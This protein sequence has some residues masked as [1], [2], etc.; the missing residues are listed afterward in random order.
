VPRKASGTVEEH[1]WADG[2]TITF[3]LRI[4]FE[5]QRQR[6]ELGTNREGWNRE[7]AD[8]ERE[9]IMGQIERG[10]WQPPEPEPDPE[11]AEDKDQETL[12]V[13]ATRYFKKQTAGQIPPKTRKDL[14]WRLSYILS[15]KQVDDLVCQTDARWVDD[16]KTWLKNIVSDH[17]KRPLK[18]RS[19][20]MVLT[21]LTSI[22]EDAVDYNVLP[23]NPGKGSRRRVPEGE[24]RRH[25][26]E[27]DMVVDFLDV[28]GRWDAE[29]H[30]SHR[31]GKRPFFALMFLAGPRISEAVGALLPQLDLYSEIWRILESK[32]SAGERD[33]DLTAF[34]LDELRPHLAARASRLGADLTPDSPL[35]P[36]REGNP[37]NENN[38]R[39]RV[40]PRIIEITNEKRL[41]AGK[42]LIPSEVTP[43]DFRRTFASLSFMAGRE[44]PY[45]MGQLGHKDSRMA[46]EVYSQVR[47][48]R[49]R[50]AERELVW[51]L[52]RFNDE[53]EAYG[54]TVV[55]PAK[56]AASR[57][58]QSSTD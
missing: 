25:V 28:A 12:R 30:Q 36:N 54:E 6:I 55:P 44:L 53:G 24:P 31:W 45:V 37:L 8:V 1:R 23:A 47:K 57:R 14:E 7:R 19:I 32:T 27:P 43:H 4:P 18:P 17:T 33:I 34:L 20:N 26:L 40:L 49:V 58:Q 39:G 10:T 11:E 15:Y 41:V 35:F 42:L 52:M 46:V 9:R 2:E 50:Q 16:F 51:R 56:L 21:C 38:I 22:L 48:R 5:G 29:V 3:R 13:A